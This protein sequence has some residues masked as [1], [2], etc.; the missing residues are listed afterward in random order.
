MTQLPLKMAIHKLSS[1]SMVIPSKYPSIPCLESVNITFPFAGNTS[2]TTK[3]LA[4]KKLL[5]N[6]SFSHVEIKLFNISFACINVV[7]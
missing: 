6:L 3:L 5:T 2:W 7:K 1:A 4:E